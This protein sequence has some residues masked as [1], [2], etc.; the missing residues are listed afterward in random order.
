MND[1]IARYTVTIAGGPASQP[2]EVRASIDLLDADLNGLGR[3]SFTDAG[4]PVP[5]DECPAIWCL[6]ICR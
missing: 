6:C 5:A 1:G 2:L 4:H 3:I